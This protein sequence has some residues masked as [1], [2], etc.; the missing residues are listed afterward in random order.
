MR[1]AS[2]W[3][4]SH[5]ATFAP[6]TCQLVHFTRRPNK[7]NMQATVRIH[8]FKDG[9]VPVIGILGIHLDLKV[10]ARMGPSSQPGGSKG[11]VA[12][13]VDHTVDQKHVGGHGCKGQT[14]IRGSRSL[15]AR[16]RM[17]GMDF[18]RDGRANRDRLV[19]D[20]STADS[21]EQVPRN[22]CRRMQNVERA[23]ART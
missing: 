1:S 2:A 14:C 17:S 6:E 7:F 13:G 23:G 9:P 10:E 22:H 16:M 20:P 18:A 12:H 21:T 4:R 5:G 3:A 15:G 8:K 19:T 11:S